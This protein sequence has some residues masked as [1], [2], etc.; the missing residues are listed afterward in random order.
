MDEYIAAAATLEL[1]RDIAR[2][3]HYVNLHEDEGWGTENDYRRWQSWISRAEA[4]IERREQAAL[5]T[6]R[7]A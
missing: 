2:W 1:R 7:R 5:T 4:E 3:T 6:A